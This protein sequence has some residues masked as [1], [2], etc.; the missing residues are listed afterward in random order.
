[1][2]IVLEVIRWWN[3]PSISRILISVTTP[4]RPT[5]LRPSLAPGKR[6]E[7]MHATIALQEAAAYHPDLNAYAAATRSWFAV[8][9]RGRR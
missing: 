5:V 3:P 8:P 2:T 6:F 1:M 9:R 4:R 7:P